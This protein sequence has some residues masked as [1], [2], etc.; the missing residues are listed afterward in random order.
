MGLRG[1]AGRREWRTSEEGGPG[2]EA[3]PVTPG[4]QCAPGAADPPSVQGGS[5]HAAGPGRRHRLGLVTPAGMG[6][7]AALA[8][9]CAGRSA[10]GMR[11]GR[12]AA[13]ARPIRWFERLGRAYDLRWPDPDPDRVT[14]RRRDDS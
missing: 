11:T 5:R 12:L 1:A 14:G 7:D 13:G 10:A 6:R 4:A 3:E 8:G 9:L 2:E